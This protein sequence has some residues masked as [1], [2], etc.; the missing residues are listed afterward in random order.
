MD[1]KDGE[2]RVLRIIPNILRVISM[3]VRW[4]LSQSGLSWR[5]PDSSFGLV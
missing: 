5:F 3:V 1:A 2:R 4:T